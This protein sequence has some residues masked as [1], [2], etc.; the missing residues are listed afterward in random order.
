MIDLHRHDEF[1]LFDGFGKPIQLAKLALDMGHKALS[2]SNHGSSSGLAETYFACKEVGIKSILGVEAY[3]QPKFDGASVKRYHLCLFAMNLAGYKNLNRILTIANLEQMYYKPIVDF[4]LLEKYSEGLICTSACVGGFINQ[5]IAVGDMKLAEKALKKYKAIFGANFYIEIQ[6]YKLHNKPGAEVDTATGLQERVNT[7]IMQLARANKVKCILTSD[8]HYGAKADYDSYCK[9]HKMSGHEMGDTYSERYM[10]TE[11]EIIERFV[12]MHGKEFEDPYRIAKKMVANLDEIVDKCE[13]D[14]L[15]QLPLKLPTVQGEDSLGTLIKEV[16]RGLKK[17]GKYTKEAIA[18]CKHEIDVISHLGFVDYFLI[19]QD[20]VKWTKEQGIMV[21]PGRGSV[22]NSLTAYALDITNIDSLYFNLDFDRFMRMDKKKVPDVDL[23]FETDRRHEVIEY[24]VKKYEGFS[25]QVVSYGLYKVDNLLNDLFKVCGV[26]EVQDKLMIKKFL[27]DNVKEEIFDYEEVQ[28]KI[29][30]KMLN[31]QF[32]NIVKHFSKMYKKIKYYGTHAAGVAITG[33]DL[34]DYVALEKH[35]GKIVTAYDLGNLELI[36]VVKFDILGLR[37]MSVLKEMQELTG[38]YFEYS[39]CEDEKIMKEFGK[40]NTDGIFQFESNGAKNILQQ[41]EADCVED[42]LAGSALNRPGPMSLKMPEAYA[43]NKRN[44]EDV[45]S[46]PWFRYSKETYGTIIYQEQ[47][48]KICRE[49]GKYEWGEVDRILKVLKGRG[50]AIKFRDREIAELKVIFYK[51][52]KAGGYSK[53]EAEHIFN[54][55]LIYSFNKGHAAGYGVISIEQMYYKVYHPEKFW[56]VTL[57]YAKKEDRFRFETIYVR[58]GGIVL[59]PH[60]N[61]GSMYKMVKFE[62]ED[63]L[64]AG[65]SNIKNVGE[66]AAAAIEAERKK[67]RFKSL[68]DFLERV[69]KRQI[70]AKVIRALQESGAL[71]FKKSVYVERIKKY[72]ST[73]YMK[74]LNR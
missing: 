67:G 56:Y 66:K 25:A 33:A 32:D 60:V 63:V 42:I 17:K 71:E 29:E 69:P 74:G 22:C 62:G 14:I 36:R 39:W 53:K 38:E 15:D 40:G 8:S 48:V 31:K 73:L 28:K 18:R 30:C 7:K 16:K 65:I 27:K 44:L 46:S 2:T 5:M 21:G 61:F 10:P 68:E 4:A 41:I 72:N 70:N 19:V 43:N 50:R 3:F 1:S 51:G 47:I 26:E 37:T 11:E 59:L 64:S 9:M 49:I 35:G 24:L 58:D 20:Y 34:I 57:K 45:K 55:L 13:A 6:P 12:K 52:A 54:V 23:D